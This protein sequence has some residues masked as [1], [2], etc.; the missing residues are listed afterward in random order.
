MLK[1]YSKSIFDQFTVFQFYWFEKN[2]TEVLH[3]ASISIKIWLLKNP[4]P[5]ELL[6]NHLA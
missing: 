2:R 4:E 6:W 5:P 1:C 3:A